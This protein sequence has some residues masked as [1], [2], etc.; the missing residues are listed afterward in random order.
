MRIGR[1]FVLGVFAS[2]AVGGCNC[3]TNGVNRVRDTQVVILTPK[4]G[5]PAAATIHFTAKATSSIGLKSLSLKVGTVA[6]KLC[7]PGSD[8][9][10]I[11]C[12]QDFP[13]S[14][15][16]SQEQNDALTLTATAIDDYDDQV[17]AVVKVVLS[18]LKVEFVQPAL[19]QTQPKP[20]ATVHGTGPLTLQVTSL[21]PI[22]KVQVTA[23]NT[24]PNNST[25]AG[26]LN[27]PA[28]TVSQS[29]N[30][31][32]L[33]IGDHILTAHV[34]DKNGATAS[35]TREINVICGS[36][37]D[38][39]NAQRCCVNDGTCN[40]MVGNG[41]DCDCDHPCPVNQGCFPGTCG[42]LPMKCRPG[43][44][45]GGTKYGDYAQVCSNEQQG[46][47]SVPA[48]CAQDSSVETCT[49][50]G[51]DP[52]GACGACAPADNCSIA[53]QNCPDAPLDRNNPAGPNNPIVHYTCMPAS[54]T[55]NMCYPAGG[56]AV[57][58]QNCDQNSNGSSYDG[59]KEVSDSC[60][61]GS[62][63]LTP[64]DSN[65]NPIGPSRCYAQCQNPCDPTNT[66]C[67]TNAELQGGSPGCPSGEICVA[68]LLGAGDQP[69][70]NGI[71][72]KPGL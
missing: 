40:P 52:N 50:P 18:G 43:C 32:N 45:P 62:M 68:S 17:P 5:T 49:R 9:T 53:S 55:T 11:D 19:T 51:D 2:V 54:P 41:A 61:K 15:Y 12:G 34:Q 31:S 24:P 46:T 63:C 26:W 33:G 10:E 16:V 56:Q 70:P 14:S 29:I 35:A 58:S 20:V 59:C 30:W 39:P 48:Y 47:G 57:D 8:V 3:G 21:V 65:Y 64:V 4:D 44:Y 1:L 6:L 66:A 69:F 36:D 25:V 37:A 7:P 72:D 23:T 67:L 60:A 22:A 42:T 71:C 13:L 38:C 28:L 27:P